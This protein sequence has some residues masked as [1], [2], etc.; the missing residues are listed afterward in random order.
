MEQQIEAEIRAAALNA[1]H[2]HIHAVGGCP[3]HYSG[4]DQTLI[5]RMSFGDIDDP[6]SVVSKLLASRK[7]HSLIAEAGTKPQIFYLT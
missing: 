6:N 5:S 3:A 2:G 4:D 7:Y 1:H